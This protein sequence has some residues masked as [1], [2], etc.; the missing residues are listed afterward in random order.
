[1]TLDDLLLDML[2]EQVV[3]VY[4]KDYEELLVTDTAYKVI[5]SDDIDVRDVY[6]EAP[7]LSF[8]ASDDKIKIE[9]DY[10]VSEED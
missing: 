9:L 4:S 2:E 6:L 10:Y 5:E 3:E 1:M 8:Q 7:I